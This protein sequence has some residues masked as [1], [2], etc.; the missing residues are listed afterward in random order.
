MMVTQEA[1]ITAAFDIATKSLADAYNQYMAE[2]SE[3]G[4]T[5]HLDTVDRTIGSIRT[6]INAQSQ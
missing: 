3:Y 2:E 1:V 6:L 5:S 4:I